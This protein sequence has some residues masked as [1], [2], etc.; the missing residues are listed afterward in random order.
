MF[1]LSEPDRTNQLPLVAKDERF[2]G[3]VRSRAGSAAELWE[4]PFFS[5]ALWQSGGGGSDENPGRLRESRI[6]PPASD[7]GC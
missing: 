5:A 3:D 2:S 4:F 7:T 1:S 6:D